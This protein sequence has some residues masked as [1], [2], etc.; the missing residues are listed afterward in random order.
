MDI[1]HHF[2]KKRKSGSS[3][4]GQ[5]WTLDNIKSGVKYFFKLH[6]HYPDQREF[7]KFEYLPSVRQIEYRYGGL[8]GLRKT[9]NLPGQNDLRKGSHRSKIAKKMWHRAKNYEAAFYSYL[10]SKIPEIRV[11]EHKVIRPGDVSSDF[12]IYT[13][14]NDGLVLDLFFAQDIPGIVQTINYK[15]KKYS[16]INYNVIFIIME[17]DGSFDQTE[18]QNLISNKKNRLEKHISIYTESYFKDH[19][20]ELVGD[21]LIAL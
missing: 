17:S 20:N 13:T 14:N 18:I 7:D 19:F 2:L 11:H 8:L 10:I 15:Q 5:R 6:G 12:F 9:L 16:K 3:S 21:K 1:D 4:M